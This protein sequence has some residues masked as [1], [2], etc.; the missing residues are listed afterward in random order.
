MSLNLKSLFKTKD[1]PK[2][3]EPVKPA[4]AP[5]EEPVPE[6]NVPNLPRI[7]L[8]ITKY[9]GIQYYEQTT[10]KAQIVLHHTVSNPKCTAGDLDT[11]KSS[12]DKIGTHFIISYD[13]KITQCIPVEYWGHHIGCSSSW[14]QSRGFGDFSTRNNALNKMAIGIEID[15]WGPVT[16]DGFTEYNKYMPEMLPIIKCDWRGAKYFQQYS[17]QQI[18]SLIELLRRLC[19]QFN[20]PYY[21]IMQEGLDVSQN[22]LSGRYGIWSHTSYRSDKSDIYQIGRAHV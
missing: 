9:T 12:K 3:A 11:W 8:D 4:P 5:I 6:V 18:I 13:G 20:I 2:P 22:A 10:N 21:G 16:Q 14:L 7:N 1:A 17:E 19:A 15:A